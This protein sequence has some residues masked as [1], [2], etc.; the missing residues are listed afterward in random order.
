MMRGGEGTRQLQRWAG[1]CG[2]AISCEDVEAGISKNWR[3]SKLSRVDECRA[4][5]LAVSRLGQDGRDLRRS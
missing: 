2:P 5:V 1:E 3:G 4:K